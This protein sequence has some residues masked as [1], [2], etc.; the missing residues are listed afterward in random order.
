MAS[1]NEESKSVIAVSDWQACYNSGDDL[2]ALSCTV[3]TV[4]E[5]ATISGAGLILNNH[6]GKTVGSF[7]AEFDGSK[8]VTLALNIPPGDISV[9]NSIMG[10]VSGEAGDQHYF[11]E[12]N[13]TITN[14]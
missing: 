1:E 2:I 8:S 4:D 6:Q 3:S 11:V 7:Y 14:C 5:N 12:Q 9:G 13:L 10:V